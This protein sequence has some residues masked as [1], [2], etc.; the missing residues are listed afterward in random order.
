V[1]RDERQVQ[2][3]VAR[4]LKALQH[5]ERTAVEL[6]RW[7]RER[8]Y[9]EEIVDEALAELVEIGEVDDERF[10]H[11]YAADKRE[12]AG[13]GAHR[14]AAALHERGIG[15]SLAA[16]AAAE[17]RE[18]ELARAVAIVHGKGEDLGE[19]RGR[20]R[21]LGLLTRRGY[22]HELAYEAVRRAGREVREAA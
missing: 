15:E 14:I 22:E 20:A 17:P 18:A 1:D 4:A 19:E 10:A 7:L 12:L 9:D 3:A 13:W 5:R 11:A 21:A 8:D 6:H 16:R 2:D